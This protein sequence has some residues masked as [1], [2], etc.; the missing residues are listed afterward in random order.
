MR[1][2]A[3]WDG[4]PHIS[5]QRKDSMK[6]TN[7]WTLDNVEVVSVLVPVVSVC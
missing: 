2:W 6:T 1:Y 5:H 7:V 3:N 4:F